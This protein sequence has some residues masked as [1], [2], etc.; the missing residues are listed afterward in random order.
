VVAKNV[1]NYHCNLIGS[2]FFTLSCLWGFC[3][4]FCW[5]SIFSQTFIFM[6]LFIL[7]L[8]AITWCV[9][10]VVLYIVSRWI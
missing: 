8:H 6:Q 4:S 3:S 10:I 9:L 7:I 5:S 2:Y 1:L